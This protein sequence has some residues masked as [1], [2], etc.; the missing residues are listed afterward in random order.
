MLGCPPPPEWL[1]IDYLQEGL[2]ATKGAGST[3]LTLTGWSALL[4]VLSVV[5]VAL[6]AG[7]WGYCK[8]RGLDKMSGYTM[9]VKGKGVTGDA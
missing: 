9:V 5:V 2:L 4:G 3:G 1:L 8:Y 7:V 6:A